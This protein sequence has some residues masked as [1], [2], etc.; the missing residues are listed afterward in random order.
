MSNKSTN[1]TT[2]TVWQASPGF[3]ENSLGDEVKGSVG[4][5]WAI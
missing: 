2:S 1:S 5:H 3:V 4:D